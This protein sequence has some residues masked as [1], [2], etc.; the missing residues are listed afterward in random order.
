MIYVMP[1][2]PWYQFSLRS[3]L[4]FTLFVAVLCSIGVGTNWA[5]SVI[6]AAIFVIGGILGGIVAGTKA[7]FVRGAWV[8]L[9]L[10][11]IAVFGSVLLFAV[12][13]RVLSSESSLWLGVAID[14]IAVLIGGIMG[15]YTARPSSGR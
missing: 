6:L 3:L 11:L 9:L 1:N 10:F 14:G 7:G 15:G 2:L 13:P 8:A 5:F 12:F 4:L